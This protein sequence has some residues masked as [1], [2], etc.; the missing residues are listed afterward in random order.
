M[1][2][3][4]VLVGYYFTQERTARTVLYLSRRQRDGVA[5]G[6]CRLIIIFFQIYQPE[7]RV[8]VLNIFFWLCGILYESV[9]ASA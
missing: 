7:I 1:A 3:A 9:V 5:Q 6:K 8:S 2:Y 4:K